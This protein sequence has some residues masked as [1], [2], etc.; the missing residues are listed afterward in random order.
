MTPLKAQL[1]SNLLIQQDALD[2]A[3]LSL[4]DNGYQH[5]NLRKSGFRTVVRA[6]LAAAAQ[7]QGSPVDLYL[8]AGS[9]LGGS[10]IA[11]SS[12]ADEL[13]R[14]P[15]GPSHSPA[16]TSALTFIACDP[17]SGDVNMWA[18]ES[19]IVNQSRS[20]R[21]RKFRYLQL[22]SG[23]PTI[24]E[25]FLANM[26]AA[27]L[28]RRVVPL[29]LT[30]TVG[31][32]L[33]RKLVAHHRLAH[34]PS[35]IYLDSAHLIGETMLELIAAWETLP[36]EGGVLFGDDASWKAVR[37]DVVAFADCVGAAS[38]AATR[39]ADVLGREIHLQA[40]TRE[41]WG[42]K[43]LAQSGL[44]HA[45]QPSASAF[46]EMARNTWRGK[47]LCTSRGNEI[48]LFRGQWMI[49]KAADAR[50]LNASD[51]SCA[52]RWLSVHSMRGT[53]VAVGSEV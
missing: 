53:S 18:W 28:S 31:F 3:N 48:L 39:T 14:D 10:L 12:V 23:Q 16:V 26:A 17:F 15:A 9:M 24:Y 45:C 50:P 34:A 8:E 11:A 30:A 40:S 36:P 5:S 22:E 47:R 6:V 21:K 2:A 43:E 41:Q 27:G 37:H 49:V 7:Q 19:V 20:E 42:A 29:R 33:I 4:V 46:H 25:R 52:A 35:V 44:L 1:L 13:R 51:P 32:R 38:P